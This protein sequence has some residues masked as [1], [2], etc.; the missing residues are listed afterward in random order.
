MSIKNINKNGSISN[1][2]DI[3]SHI[4]SMIIEI[5]DF[6]FDD[7]GITPKNPW[8]PLPEHELEQSP[9]Y[10]I[11]YKDKDGFYRCRLHSKTEEKRPKGLKVMG[12][13]VNSR[14][15]L[16]RSIHLSEIEHHCKFSN[17]KL[18]K[19]EIIARLRLGD[20]PPDSLQKQGVNK[21]EH[22]KYK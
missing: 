14:P 17:P 9:C 13:S 3:K 19:S 2:G 21:A 5:E 22:Y 18:H 12:V 15:A 1:D 7:P 4:Y 11:I 10:P 20:M 8:K 16:I 6:F